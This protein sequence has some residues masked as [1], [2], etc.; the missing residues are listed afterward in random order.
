MRNE[1]LDAYWA[2][3]S[4]NVKCALPFYSRDFKERKKKKSICRGKDVSRVSVNI[5][6]LDTDMAVILINIS[7]EFCLPQLLFASQA[8]KTKPGLSL[9]Q[10]TRVLLD[11]AGL[12]NFIHKR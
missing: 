12:T 4:E 10:G 7:I 5:F 11:H 6:L 9:N 3:F 1:V 8:I 2:L